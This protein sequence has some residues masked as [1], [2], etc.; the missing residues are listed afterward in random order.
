MSI[1]E[2]VDLIQS[3]QHGY[4]PASNFYNLSDDKI[5]KVRNIQKANKEEHKKGKNFCGQAII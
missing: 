2:L 1:T 4:S 5:N 3:V